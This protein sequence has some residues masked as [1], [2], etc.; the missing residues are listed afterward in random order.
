MGRLRNGGI[1]TKEEYV[2][3]TLEE[4]ETYAE[5]GGFTTRIVEKN[6]KSFILTMDF[7]SE[8]LNFRV[9]DGFVTDVYG[10]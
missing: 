5:R 10:G 7:R 2:G 4:A 1:I 3:K 6:G 9:F 8:R